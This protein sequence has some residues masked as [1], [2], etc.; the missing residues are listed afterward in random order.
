MQ[1]LSLLSYVGILAMTTLVMQ[2]A[3]VNGLDTP[4][5]QN[6]CQSYYNVC[7]VGCNNGTSS[8]VCPADVEGYCSSKTCSA[9]DGLVCNHF[10]SCSGKFN[11]SIQCAGCWDGCTS[12]M[13][14]PALEGLATA[15]LANAKMEK[16]Q[17][18]NVDQ[19]ICQD[20]QYACEHVS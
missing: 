19:V 6:S 9:S 13:K 8:V 2:G 20:L 5:C 17:I 4:A 7:V 10:T 3:V 11:K 16:R 18:T 14:T 15:D 1:L 12:D